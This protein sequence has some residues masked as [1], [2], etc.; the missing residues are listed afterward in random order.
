MPLYPAAWECA[1][2]TVNYAR[3]GRNCRSSVAKCFWRLKAVAICACCKFI[4]F[5]VAAG[6]PFSEV[7]TPPCPPRH[8]KSG[9]FAM[10][11]VVGIAASG[12]AQPPLAP[13]D[14]DVGKM[15][16][17]GKLGQVI[18]QEP[19]ATSVAGVQACR[20]AYISSN[21]ADKPTISKG[22]ASQPGTCPGS[23]TAWPESLRR[24]GVPPSR[25]R[26]EMREQR[27][28]SGDFR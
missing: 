18:A 21:M 4:R 17:E 23:P 20:I 16:P 5:K 27:Q 9:M 13:F 28:V 2:L 10:A 1:I 15:K 26:T 24:T 25:C 7:N 11:I 3:A 19:V 8:V 22:A 12:Y 6:R 14:Q